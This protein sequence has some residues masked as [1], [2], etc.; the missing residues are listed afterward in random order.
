MLQPLVSSVSQHAHLTSTSV[1][2]ARYESEMQVFLFTKAA[3]IERQPGA[4]NLYD[5]L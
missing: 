1:T 3:S 4:A 2:S 5:A